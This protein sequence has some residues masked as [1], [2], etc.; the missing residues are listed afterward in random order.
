MII[1]KIVAGFCGNIITNMYSEDYYFEM[2]KNDL[3]VYIK[4]E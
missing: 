1:V 4:K 2:F 3:V